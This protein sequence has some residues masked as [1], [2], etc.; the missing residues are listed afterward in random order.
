MPILGVDTGGTF[1]D[2]YL[3]GD[4]GTV[5]VYKRPSTPDDP[6]RAILEGLAESPL[7]DVGSPISDLVHGT[8]VAT[9]AI[10]ERKGARTGLI[11]TRG[12]R[13]VLVIGRQ[14]RPKLYDLS[15]HREPPLVPDG[16]RFEAAERLDFRGEV[17]APL[18]PGAVEALLDDVQ[19]AGVESL[20]VCFLFSFVNPD[21]E[22]LV[23]EAAR[24]RGITVS[25]SHEVL[26][27]HREYERTS[28][29]VANAYVAPVM[30]QYLERL[31]SGLRGHRV[32]RLRVMSSNGG[33]ISPRSAG[34]LA[35][36][37]AVSGPAGGVAGAF[38]LARRAGFDRV[39]TFDMGGTSTDVSLCPGRI[40]ERDET[41]VG[42][43]PIRGP[44]VDVLS[45][46]AGGGSIA[47]IDAGGALRVGPE[48]AGAHPGPA[49]YGTGSE[50]TVTDAQVALGRI[51]PEHFLGGRMALNPELSLKALGSIAGPFGG[52]PLAAAA[53]VLRVANANMERAPARLRRARP[54]P[55]RFHARRLRRR[56]PAP[57]VR[58]RS[59]S[60]HSAC[61]HSAIPGRAVRARHGHGADHQGPRGVGAPACGLWRGASRRSPAAAFRRTC[62]TRSPRPRRA[63]IRRVSHRR[64]Q[65][66]NDPG[67]ALRRAV[68]RAAGRY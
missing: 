60:P 33:S 29:T 1:T 66:A 16:L 34:R 25:A 41:H 10:I 5:T 44:T 11:T 21:H 35:V 47:R 12:F 67:H 42:E 37:T 58:P 7:A 40:L 36:R 43:L 28:T 13:D 32:G 3:L 45:V 51:D 50:P 57:R 52:D 49:C 27:E 14:T 39:I 17:L 20:A 68:L 63:G 48:S 8:T 62:R 30:T 64:R 2:F 31:E 56:R 46:G 54:R 65:R 59:R 18:D 23:A 15:P 53:A 55:A 6:S 61:P 24:R 38:D 26:P 9:N 22:R 4:D 19:A